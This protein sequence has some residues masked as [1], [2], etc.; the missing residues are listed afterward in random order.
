[1]VTA[2]GRQNPLP[3]Q[4]GDFLAV[5]NAAVAD[6][7]DVDRAGIFLSG[8]M[9]SG[10]IAA[11]ARQTGTP[12][13]EL[14]GF[15]VT[16]E[17][18]IDDREGYFAKQTAE[19]LGIP[20]DLLS[21]DEIEPF[22][23]EGEEFV[24][25]EPIADPLLGIS[26]LLLGSAA[27]HSRVALNGEGADNLFYCQIRPYAKDLLRSGQWRTLASAVGAYS[28]ERRAKWR[29]L[30]ALWERKLDSQDRGAAPSWIEA[31]FAR[32]M[33]L[34]D[35][36]D[37]YAESVESRAHP[38]VPEAHASL[39]LP[40]WPA[41]CESFDRGFMRHNIEVRFPFLDLR[42]VEFALAL[43]PYPLFQRKKIE[44]DAM[45]GRLPE[46]V[47]AR[48]KTLLARDVSAESVR[49]RNIDWVAEMRWDG[50]I[51][52]YIHRDALER[53][54]KLHGDRGTSCIHA[55]CLNSWL[56]SARRVRY[57]SFMEAG[58]G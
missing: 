20:L 7:L 50:E 11:T 43:P 22:E 33:K 29:S 36:P 4:R 40:I 5:L 9:D 34:D 54:N 53:E 37:I 12:S 3:A 38:I 31:N 56:Q 27:K 48:D 42:M 16:C 30:G 46:S 19:F 57:N 52:Q 1:L 15:T 18:L 13:S 41:L 28:W 14:R 32:R 44:R 8:G 51:S 10:A 2:G 45:K 26:R 21:A 55:F 39:N 6:R 17:T 25:P 35:R 23:G 47:L 58:H 24:Y 49:K